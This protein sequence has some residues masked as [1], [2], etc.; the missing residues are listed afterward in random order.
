ME[1]IYNYDDAV[2]TLK[3]MKSFSKWKAKHPE[4]HKHWAAEDKIKTL[5]KD[6]GI[7]KQK[8]EKVGLVQPVKV[9]VSNT[10]FLALTEVLKKR[11]LKGFDFSQILDQALETIPDEWWQAK[12]SELSPVEWKIQEIAKKPELNEKLTGAINQLLKESLESSHH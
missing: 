12:I 10:D 4:E 9:S 1:Q 7:K 5:M 11:G 2:A 8:V 3:K 6:A